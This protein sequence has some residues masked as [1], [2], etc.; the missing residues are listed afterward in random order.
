MFYKFWLTQIIP[1]G[2]NAIP[3]SN[4]VLDKITGCWLAQKTAISKAI[5]QRLGNFRF[6]VNVNDKS[7]KISVREK[8]TFVKVVQNVSN[9]IF[10]AKSDK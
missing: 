1:S 9:W 2:K 7:K 5:S 10:F 8:F 6:F 4:D 3:N